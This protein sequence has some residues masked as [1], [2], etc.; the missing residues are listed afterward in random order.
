M[1]IVTGKSKKLN[2]TQLELLDFAAITNLKFDE[3]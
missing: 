1:G 3:V 2:L